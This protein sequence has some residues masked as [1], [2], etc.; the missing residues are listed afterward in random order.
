MQIKRNRIDKTKKNDRKHE[1]KHQ[2]DLL[3][4]R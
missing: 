4:L 2:S 3:K 1:Q